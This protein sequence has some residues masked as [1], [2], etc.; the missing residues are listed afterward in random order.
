M[1]MNMDEAIL[2]NKAPNKPQL[3]KMTF[4]DRGNWPTDA[5]VSSERQWCLVQVEVNG[6]VH[7]YIA[8][9]ARSMISHVYGVVHMFW[10]PFNRT[11]SSLRHVE[12]ASS[13]SR[14]RSYT[15]IR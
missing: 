2:F 9:T 7:D 11:T 5:K 1:S 4:L 8:F 13:D 15:C 10:I 14:V 12:I 3:Y 6:T